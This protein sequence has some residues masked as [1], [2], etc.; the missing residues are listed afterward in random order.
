MAI[1]AIEIFA[2]LI[3]AFASFRRP[4][5]RE[6]GLG[7][8]LGVAAAEHAAAAIFVPL[9]SSSLG[10]VHAAA[11]TAMRLAFVGFAAT[12]PLCVHFA[13]VYRGGSPSRWVLPA[14]YA[15]AGLLLVVG[16]VD[17]VPH[18]D[19][20]P[21]ALAIAASFAQVAAAAASLALVAR[22][23]LDGAAGALPVVV[24]AT[25]FVATALSDLAS[26]SGLFA[27]GALGDAGVAAFVLGIAT[28]PSARYAAAMRDL[29][30]RG[31][32]L[33]SLTRELQQSYEKLDAAQEELGKKEQLAAVGELAAVIAHEVRNPLAVIANAVASLR[34]PVI[35]RENHDLLLTILDEETSRLNRLVTDL[36]RYARP[37][38]LQRS[39][40]VLRDLLER[41]LALASTGT[42]NIHMEFKMEAFEGRLWGDANLL[43]Q[44]FD[45][46]I[47]NAVQAMGSG[48]VL[49]IRVRAVTEDGTDGLAVDIIDTGEGMDTQVRSRA[50]DPFFTT[51]PSGTGLG[52]A[53]VDRIVE[54]HGGHFAIDSRA[55]EG[56]TVTVFLPHGSPS[57]P[58]PRI[59]T[60]K[61]A[62]VGPVGPRSPPRTSSESP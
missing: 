35:A 27:A 11:A 32:E 53:I 47:D 48:G 20:P 18:A 38:N 39:Q 56:T 25:V 16:L 30:R 6:F 5:D 60:P 12:L 36:L 46:L 1:A 9:E 24:G 7:A 19:G 44:V 59:R 61:P 8:L 21:Q 3:L 13:L 57:E 2:G 14:V 42:K 54:A 55:G 4:A 33:R 62:A 15:A 23:F 51:R 28:M 17:R 41:A 22:A 45:N 43:R 31:R 50:R 10:I 26:A 37:V 40:F 29:D 49:T 58:P 52:L 34:R